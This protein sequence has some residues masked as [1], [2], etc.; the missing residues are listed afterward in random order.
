[1]P[2]A[3]F[4]AS[5]AKVVGADIVVRDERGGFSYRVPRPAGASYRPEIQGIYRFAHEPFGGAF[6]G[7]Y[8]F[9]TNDVTIPHT[10]YFFSYYAYPESRVFGDGSYGSL[11]EM[12][13]D[14]GGTGDSLKNMSP[15]E[16][17]K[18]TERF[19]ELRDSMRSITDPGEMLVF[20]RRIAERR[21][22]SPS[23]M[24]FSKNGGDEYI[25]FFK[26]AVIT[27]RQAS[28]P[29]VEGG[30]LGTRLAF[31]INSEQIPMG[32]SFVDLSENALYF[33]HGPRVVKIGAMDFSPRSGE[34]I[35]AVLDKWRDAIVLANP[36]PES[37]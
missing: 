1:M 22:N 15:E 9:L 31:R 34:E 5:E 19:K 33:A 25:T 32:R 11:G 18:M 7:R 36:D 26:D 23:I 10:I 16:R 24:D 12:F 2:L 35:F 21:W 6:T 28:L 13:A 37:H 30:A 14:M 4:G 3:A 29:A 17:A 27:T 8:A 20:F